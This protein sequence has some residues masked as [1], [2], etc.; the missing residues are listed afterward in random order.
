MLS[1]TDP[2]LTWTKR[3]AIILSTMTIHSA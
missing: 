3:Y 2:P 1:N